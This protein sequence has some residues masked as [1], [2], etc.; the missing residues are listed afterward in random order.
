MFGSGGIAEFPVRLDMTTFACV[1]AL[2]VTFIVEFADFRFML[3]GKLADIIAFAETVEFE[4]VIADMVVVGA[5]EDEDV[6]VVVVL[7]V[8]FEVVEV[9]L[10]AVVVCLD[11]VGEDDVVPWVVAVVDE[12]VVEDEVDVV[13]FEVDAVVSEVVG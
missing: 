10:G 9:V 8:V 4:M 6:G 12:D 1:G 11:V 13:G 7:V 3:R 5:V 2:D